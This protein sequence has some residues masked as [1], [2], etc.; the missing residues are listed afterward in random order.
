MMSDLRPS[1]ESLIAAVACGPRK[2]ARDFDLLERW[3]TNAKFNRKRNS[4]DR[5]SPT[6]SPPS[7]QLQIDHDFIKELRYRHMSAGMILFREGDTATESFVV[8]SG[9]LTVVVR[10]SEICKLG[11]GEIVG[12]DS[13]WTRSMRNAT[14]KASYNFLETDL[15]VVPH[16]LLAKYSLSKPPVHKLVGNLRRT[17]IKLPSARHESELAHLQNWM[18]LDASCNANDAS[19]NIAKF[20]RQVD[21]MKVLCGRCVIRQMDKG[22]KFYVILAGGAVVHINR[23]GVVKKLQA[24]QYFGEQV[25]LLRISHTASKHSSRMH[26]PNHCIFPPVHCR[27]S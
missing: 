17:L 11:E 12:V 3:L 13:L 10:G 14:V 16:E 2:S 8:L 18:K 20:Y 15:I 22:D 21:Y 6:C 27:P 24:G 1:I 19:N 9:S 5:V 7:L 4:R 25:S 26:P 23:L